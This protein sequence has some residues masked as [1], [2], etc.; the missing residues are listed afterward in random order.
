MKV[1]FLD[2]DGVLNSTPFF[3]AL[4]RR[5]PGV[6]RRIYDKETWI[7]MLD[8]IAV[9]R[10]DRLVTGAGAKVV[11]S[12]SWRHEHPPAQIAGFLKHH[13]FTG[14]V[15][16]ATP[17]LVG[18]GMGRGDEIRLWLLRQPQVTAFVV[19]DDIRDMG[20]VQHAL[21]NTSMQSGLLDFHVDRALAI[22][23]S[24]ALR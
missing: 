6:I 2:I 17:V 13:G 1:V 3:D 16:D 23:R 18:E 20:P 4:R 10:L 7:D 9:R 11:I 21:V 24:E 8:P 14:V 19:L 22:L 15:I 5:E 12:S